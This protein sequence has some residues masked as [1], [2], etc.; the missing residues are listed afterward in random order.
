MGKKT[1]PVPKKKKEVKM[2]SFPNAL[3]EVITGGKI[4]KLEWDN[5][6]TY[7]FLQDGFLCI[8]NS[9]DN[10][11]HALLIKEADLTGLDWM[12]LDDKERVLN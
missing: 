4:T 9:G 1:T 3:M 8:H 2:L 7:V 10:N 11:P 6:D 5:K 12:V